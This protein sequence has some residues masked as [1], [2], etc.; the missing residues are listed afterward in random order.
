MDWGGIIVA[1]LVGT[2]VFTMLMYGGPMM[3]MPR[4][5]IPRLLGSMMLP[6]GGT[7]LAVG[8]MM[9]FANGILFTI[10]YAAIW[11]AFGNN[12]TWWSGIIFGAVHSVVAAGGIGAISP[13][14]KEIK[15]GRLPSPMS[16]GAKGLLGM[17]MGH[18]VFGLVVALVYGAF[19]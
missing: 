10:I 3:G 2:A 14:H 12:V 1:G 11:N 15:A 17:V 4:M 18:V 16:G 19:V 6:Q 9:H 8:M 7:A 13:M 5:D